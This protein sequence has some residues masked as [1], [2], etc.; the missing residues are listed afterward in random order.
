MYPPVTAISRTYLQYPTLQYASFEDYHNRVNTINVASESQFR[1][2]RCCEPCRLAKLK[3]SGD[4][5]A[6]TRCQN[7]PAICTYAPCKRLGRRPKQ[8]KKPSQ[9]PLTYRSIASAVIRDDM[10][11]SSS[12]T[13]TRPINSSNGVFD[14]VQLLHTKIITSENGV[15]SVGVDFST[16]S[17]WRII[18]SHGTFQ[19]ANQKAGLVSNTDDACSNLYAGLLQGPQLT[20]HQQQPYNSDW[21]TTIAPAENPATANL[22]CEI[23]GQCP[24]IFAL[25][26]TCC[27]YSA[28]M[29]LVLGWDPSTTVPL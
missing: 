23:P 22:S 17:T 18:E 6:C 19:N 8:T 12:I 3:C 26:N 1:L 13:P 7:G 15:P 11:A 28:L 10:L 20:W 5:P 2:R 14:S 4:K 27:H 21:T 29:T 16:D 25:D 24:S 9:L